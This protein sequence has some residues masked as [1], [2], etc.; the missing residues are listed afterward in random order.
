[1]QTP[2]HVP[3]FPGVEGY[4]DPRPGLDAVDHKCFDTIQNRITDLGHLASGLITVLTEL[5]IR[6]LILVQ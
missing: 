2:G 4:A 5:S 3:L 6:T 1:M